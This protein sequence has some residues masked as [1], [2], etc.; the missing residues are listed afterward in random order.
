MS[1]YFFWG[2]RGKIMHNLGED[3]A[4]N[5]RTSTSGSDN[6]SGDGGRES[7]AA[8]DA[9]GPGDDWVYGDE[10]DNV[11]MGGD[12]DDVLI[13]EEGGDTLDGGHGADTLFGEFGGLYYDDALNTIAKP[14]VADYTWATAAL[15]A[16]VDYNVLFAGQPS[17]SDR[18]N[19]IE[20]FW[21][22]SGNDSITGGYGANEIRG[23][24]GRDTISGGNG[25]DTLWGQGGQDRLEGGAGSDT[26]VY[27][28]NTSPVHVDFVHHLVSFPGKSWPAETISSIENAVGGSGKD[29]FHGNGAAN[30]FE[31]GRG[32]DALWGGGGSDTAS[33]ASETRAMKIDLG[34]QRATVIGTTETDELHS[35]ENAI[36]GH[37]KDNILG[38]G[39]KN[40]LDGGDGA[41]TVFA[42]GG[43][44]TVS[45]SNGSDHL[46]GGAGTDTLVWNATYANYFDLVTAHE[47]DLDS[48]LYLSD[49]YDGD[50]DPD[51]IIDLKAGT[52]VLLYGKGGTSS[53][54]GFEKV[55]TGVG[56]D[57]VYGTEGADTISVGHGA[58]FVQ[59]RGGNDLLE[60]S[61]V[62]I[63]DDPI[64]YYLTDNRDPHE[65]LR[66]GAGNDT[67]VGASN[68]FGDA[69]ND[70]LVA[71]WDENNMTGGAGADRF[72]FSDFIELDS[73]H[74]A[75][76]VVQH[77]RILDF[78]SAEGDRLVIERTDPG[79]PLPDF[80]GEVDTIYEIDTGQYGFIGNQL[81]MPLA[82][83][84]DF[85]GYYSF[86]LAVRV[87]G[88][89][90]EG[91]I[92]F[93]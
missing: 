46:H 40:V 41:D 53:L 59:G 4:N 84:Y 69:G 10:H 61:N 90:D 60:G 58:N 77:G 34:H 88:D 45:I 20:D 35:I 83:G 27:S 6:T 16:N 72:V 48:G 81:Y 70:R 43:A 14:D 78:D 18:L 91:D 5:Y 80:V 49:T 73:W 50:A 82:I 28:D 62:E 79:Q 51:L 44:D 89:I 57:Y 75:D 86:G 11:L 30:T 29:L 55:S 54:D 31:G 39:A 26:V 8:I 9:G 23:G 52:A 33:Y 93:A 66:G 32:A 19:G 56:N 65:T 68:A 25:D 67:V 21:S 85:G 13:G 37:G 24:N 71:G 64:D 15:T 76:A 74:T 92:V 3:T 36:G 1:N 38:T 87:D 22:G 63:D 42:G 17:E 2:E 7:L 12:G 47:A